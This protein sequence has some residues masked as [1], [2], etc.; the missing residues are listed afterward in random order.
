MPGRHVGEVETQFHS[1]PTSALDTKVIGQLHASAT[2]NS[3]NGPPVPIQQDCG[4]V[5]ELV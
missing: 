4:C 5:P 2:L 3:K 1:F